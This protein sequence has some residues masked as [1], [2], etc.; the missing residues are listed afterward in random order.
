MTPPDVVS[1]ARQQ[2]NAV[3]DAFF[4]DTELYTHIWH[5]QDILAKECK[6]IE[7]TYTTSTVI[8]QQE[9]S[10]P[11]TA[12]AMKRVTYAGKRL[13]AMTLKDD[14]LL[15]GFNATTS[16][17]GTPTHYAIFDGVIYLRPVPSAVGTLK[18]FTF[19]RPGQVS[20]TSTLDVPEEFH[21]DLV[22][23]VLW[24]MASKDQNFQGAEFYRAQ[25]D[26]A[27]ERCKRWSRKRQTADGFNVVRD[28]AADDLPWWGLT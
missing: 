25:W 5:A 1:Y 4:A 11:T 13:L 23:F 8:G 18:L 10:Y 12:T 20:A 2:Y 26:A 6:A 21:L 24:R 7:N 28:E 19:D 17:T 3:N 14:D 16:A 27:V 15:T 9:Y 22:S